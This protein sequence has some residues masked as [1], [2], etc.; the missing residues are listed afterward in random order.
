MPR[1]RTISECRPPAVNRPFIHLVHVMRMFTAMLALLPLALLAGCNDASTSSSGLPGRS[2][3]GA[4]VGNVAPELEGNDAE[5]N[6]VK[7]SNYKGKVVLVDFWATWCGPCVGMIPHEK[8]LVKKL[9]GRPFAL[10][11]VSADQSPADLAK[12]LAK[13]NLPW[14]NIFDGPGGKRTWEWN[15]EAFPTFYIIDAKGI[16]RSKIVGARQSRTPDHEPAGRSRGQVELMLASRWWVSLNRPTGRRLDAVSRPRDR[17]YQV[18][19]GDVAILPTRGG[20]YRYP[21]GRKKWQTFR[22]GH[23][24]SWGAARSNLWANPIMK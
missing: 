6:P 17:A 22:R 20:E 4:S 11:G 14:A 15:V 5:G 10:I 18:A 13:E 2:G 3:T 24:A 12:F 9:E 19:P 21:F 16:I 23:T 8:E 7:L 1:E